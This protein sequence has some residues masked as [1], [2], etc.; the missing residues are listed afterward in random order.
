M[1]KDAK[2][3]PENTVFFMDGGQMYM[4]S[5]TLGSDPQLLSALSRSH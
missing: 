4:V 5:G 1:M 2:N 3:V